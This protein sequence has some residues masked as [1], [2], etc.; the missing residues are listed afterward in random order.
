MISIVEQLIIWF[1]PS[2]TC[3]PSTL[4]YRTM[5][6]QYNIPAREQKD[7]GKQKIAF[8]ILSILPSPENNSVLTSLLW[9]ESWSAAIASLWARDKAIM[10][11]DPLGFFPGYMAHPCGR[12]H[13]KPKSESGNHTATIQSQASKIHQEFCLCKLHALQRSGKTRYL[14]VCSYEEELLNHKKHS[15]DILQQLCFYL[16]KMLLD[17]WLRGTWKTGIILCMISCPT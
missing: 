9:T 17:L 13:F 14:L 8:N 16:H 10:I 1:F 2:Q 12:L 3:I 4:N 6:I 15:G 11:K 5:E 7:K